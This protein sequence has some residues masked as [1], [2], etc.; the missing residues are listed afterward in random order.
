M[1]YI[2]CPHLKRSYHTKPKPLII[3]KC[4]RFTRLFEFIG[5]DAA[6]KMGCRASQGTH[7][8]AQLLLL[9]AMEPSTVKDRT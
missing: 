4:F 9:W 7:Q 8:F 5:Y 1:V 6:D 3:L 2:T